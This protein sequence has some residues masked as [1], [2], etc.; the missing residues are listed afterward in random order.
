MTNPFAIQKPVVLTNLSSSSSGDISGALSSIFERYG[1]G[2]PVQF[3]GQSEDMQTMMAKMRAASGDLLV[4]YGGDGT[5]AAV[6]S[7]ARDQNV[8]F[9]ALPG[10]TMNMLM[11]GLYGSGEWEAC[12]MSALACAEPRPMR[13]GI[14]R[15]SHGQTGSF[16]VGAMFGKPTKMSEAR[17]ELR[18][19]HV[20]EAAKGAMTAM[21]AT[22]DAAPIYFKQ[23]DSDAAEIP[24]DL[25]NVTCPFMDGQA[26]DPDQ[27][28]LTLFEK[29]TGGSTVALGFAALLGNIRQS[30][31]AEHI[32]AEKFQLRADHTI[33]A[34]LD[35]EPHTFGGEV[36]VELNPSH[37]LVM[38]PQPAMSFGSTPRLEGSV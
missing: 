31:A 3:V 21:K 37:G 24:F 35:G 32:K 18:G 28:D 12:L 36:S 38:A 4:S 13:A 19:G 10:G 22:Y 1:Y 27:F 20:V 25:L 9:I 5:A 29:V 16:L 34:L 26:L 2:N 11:V 15:D 30:E 14:V 6:A 7:I 8:P 33:E 23:D 17:E